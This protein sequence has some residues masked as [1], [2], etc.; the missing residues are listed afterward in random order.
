MITNGR[1]VPLRASRP[2]VASHALAPMKRRHP[3][4]NSMACLSVL[5]VV[6]GHPLFL[7]RQQGEQPDAFGEETGRPLVA[8]DQAGG[9][10]AWIEVY[11]G[12]V[13]DP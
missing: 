10:P 11:Q 9:D 13:D 2:K 7:E 1:T 6:I 12:G 8:F 3:E 4:S 5:L